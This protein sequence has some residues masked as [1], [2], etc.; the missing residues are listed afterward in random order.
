MARGAYHAIVHGIAKSGQDWGTNTPTPTCTYVTESLCS[1]LETNTMLQINS[2]SIKIIVFIF[3]NLFKN[4]GSCLCRKH[5]VWDMPPSWALEQQS[6]GHSCWRVSQCE[7]GRAGVIMGKNRRVGG[8][9]RNGNN[10][11]FQW[12]LLVSVRHWALSVISLNPHPGKWLFFSLNTMV[13]P[14][15]KILFSALFF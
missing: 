3:H 2:T 14:G 10:N 11:N 15:F 7:P 13:D 5:V 4:F 12:V 8:K 1:T 6:L 9:M